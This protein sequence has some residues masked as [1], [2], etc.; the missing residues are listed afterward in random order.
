MATTAD[1]FPKERKTKLPGGYM[2]KVLRV[3]LTTGSF[4]DE[5]LPEEPVL[6]NF[7]GGQALANYILLRELPLPLLLD[8][9]ADVHLPVLAG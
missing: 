8:H 4:K 7:I 9:P 3:D 2:G 5:N 1:I 6:R